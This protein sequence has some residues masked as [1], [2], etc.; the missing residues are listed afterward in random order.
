MATQKQFLAQ[1]GLD[2]NNNTITNVSDPVN[3]QDAATKNWAG[4]A[5]NLASGTLAAARL[6]AFSGDATSTAGTS[7]LTLANS[8]VTAG[9]YTQVTVDAKGRVTLGA[10]ASTSSITEG[11]NLYYTDARARSAVS[12]GTGITYNSTTGVI[13]T[14][15]IPNSSLANSSVTIGTTAI[16]LGASSTTLAGLTSV[17]ST[18]FTGALT[19]NASTATTL[20]TARTI[21]GVSFNGSANI[22]ITSTATNALTIGTGLSGTSYNGSAAVT[23]ANTGVLSITGT[24][25]QVT[26]SASTGAVTL[27][28]PQDIAT[29]SNVTFGN[30]TL[31]GNLTVNGTT[32]SVNSTVSTVVDPIINIGGGTNGAAPTTNDAK[33]RGIAFQWHNGTVAKTG[34]FGYD[35]STGYL[36]FVPDATITGEVVSGTAGDISATNFRGAL[37]GNASTATSATTATTAGAWTTSR[38]L[39]LGGDLSGSVSMNGSA[40]VTLTATIAANSVALGTDTTGNY[41]ATVAGGTGVTVS[42]SGSETAAVT[43]SIGQAIGTTDAVT[44]GS[45]SLDSKIVRDTST[46]TTTATTANQVADT[47]SATGFR[48][49]KYLIQITSS[50]S[51]H[52]T[53]MLVIHDGTT[54]SLVRYADIMTGAS[55]ATID[56]DISAGSVRILV[57]PTNAA[58]T[59][60]IAR[61][62][63]VV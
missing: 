42:G 57:T 15:S 43:V 60:I 41:V 20:Q 49:A 38:T 29:S 7:A 8:G 6:P 62:L 2:N 32:T 9:T 37:I 56:A 31:S 36:T 55:L 48:T 44:F 18:G 61:T 50:T 63:F 46:L 54:V 45:M 13:G 4:N 52:A 58:T 27:S 59:F 40:D 35:N 12:A 25:N 34:F 19:G 23:I 24:A 10:T 30:L 26:A 16:A 22:T 39:T 21:N 53:E 47:Y 51:Y 11:A 28:L 5:S 33:D 3:A 1:R 14:A 17:T